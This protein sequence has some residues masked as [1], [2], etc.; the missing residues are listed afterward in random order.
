MC[1]AVLQRRFTGTIREN[2]DPF[3]QYSDSQLWDALG[4]SSKDA[5]AAAAVCAC[6]AST[7]SLVSPC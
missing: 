7:L 3:E 6:S 2:I 5:V 1:V 4:K